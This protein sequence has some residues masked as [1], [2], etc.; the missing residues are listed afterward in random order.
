MEEPGKSPGS[1]FSGSICQRGTVAKRPSTREGLY[2][3]F[4]TEIGATDVE[5]NLEEEE[6]LGGLFDWFDEDED[7]EL[8]EAEV[9]LFEGW[10]IE[11][12]PEGWHCH[13]PLIRRSRGW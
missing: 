4:A 12:Q 9:G 1:F 6:F 11:I 7:E 3:T 13:A 8:A 10:S 5:A 2:T